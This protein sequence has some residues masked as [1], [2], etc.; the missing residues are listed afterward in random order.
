[1]AREELKSRLQGRE[2]W[3]PR[4]FNELATLGVADGV[5]EEAGDIVRRPGYRVTFT[6]E[7]QARRGCAAGGVSG[8]ALHPALGGG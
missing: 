2:K 4:V 3:T 5:V 8:A 7:R 6:P 1:M